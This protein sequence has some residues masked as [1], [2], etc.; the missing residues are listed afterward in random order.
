[1]T[2]PIEHIRRKLV[3]RISQII[4][5]HHAT[6]IDVGSDVACSCGAQALPHHSR[7]VA[8]QIVDQLG[9]MQDTGSWA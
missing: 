7:H 9:L 8:D 3:D 6:S 2:D 5:D 4:D 1:M